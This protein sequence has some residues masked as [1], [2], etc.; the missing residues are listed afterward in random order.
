MF[1][2]PGELGATRDH[3]KSGFF[4]SLVENTAYDLIQ[5]LTEHLIISPTAQNK[6]NDDNS[7]ILLVLVKMAKAKIASNKS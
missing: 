6:F 4:S 7:T 3:K 1:H 2:I 5:P